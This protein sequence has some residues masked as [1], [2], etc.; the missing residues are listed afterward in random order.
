MTQILEIFLPSKPLNSI[1]NFIR[2]WRFISQAENRLTGGPESDWNMTGIPP[3]FSSNCQFPWTKT[4][5]HPVH[6][7]LYGILLSRASAKPFM[8]SFLV[9]KC[10]LQLV[11]LSVQD[12]DVR[13]G[14][15]QRC[16][17]LLIFLQGGL[18][19]RDFKRHHLKTLQ[20]CLPVRDLWSVCSVCPPPPVT[21]WIHS[22]S[23]SGKRKQT[24]EKCFSF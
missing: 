15:Q 7:M 21:V 14:L 9:C 6:W 23:D 19:M 18:A 3:P 4:H 5:S 12:S 16:P 22:P 13:L 24:D 2:H 10:V 20:K 17:Q 11:Q 8:L 1:L